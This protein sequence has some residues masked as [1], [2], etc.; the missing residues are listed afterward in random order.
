M[1]DLMLVVM[2]VVVYLAGFV[3]G[4]FA[5]RRKNRGTDG[6]L[7]VDKVMPEANG[8]VYFQAFENPQTYTDGQKI[9]LEVMWFTEDDMP[10]SAVSQEEQ[11]L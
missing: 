1:S 4:I 7:I 5:E 6:I 2:I 9:S 8:G 11:E 3:V 10:A